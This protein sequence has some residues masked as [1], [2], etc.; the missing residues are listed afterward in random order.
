MRN[1]TLA[2]I[3][4]VVVVGAVALAIIGAVHQNAARHD[5]L[6]PVMAEKGLCWN[7]RVS[8]WE[9]CS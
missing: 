4:G 8:Q 2:F 6:V 5:A 1:E 3:V 7:K 9:K